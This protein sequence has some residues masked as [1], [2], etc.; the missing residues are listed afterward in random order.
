MNT[1]EFLTI[2]AAIVPDRTAIVG[3]GQRTTYAELQ[4]TANRLANALQTLGVA[5]GQN[6]GVMAVNSPAFV[7]VYY[8]TASVGAT[9]VPLNFRAKTEELTHMVN[10]ADVSVL[11]IGERYWPIYEQIK[12]SIP[13]VRQVIGL[14]FT[15]NGGANYQ[16]LIDAN[17]DI[18]VYTEIDDSD[19][20]LLIYTSGTTSLPKGVVLSYQA[21]TALVVNTQAPAD[22]GSEQEVVLVSAPFFHIAGATT[23]MSA[24]FSGRRLVVLPQFTPEAWLDAVDAEGVTHAFVVPTMLKRT[25]EYE[26]FGKYSLKT[27][28]LI[29]YGAAPMPYDVVRAAVE[30]FPPR[31]IGLLNAYGQTEATG[32]LTYLGPDDHHLNGTPEK[33]DKKLLRLRSVG[34]TMPDVDVAILA[35]DGRRL[36]GDDEGE[37]CIKGDRVMKGY[38]KRE[39]DTASAIHDGWLHTGD[40]GRIDED[41]YLFITGRIKDMIIRGGENISTAEIENVLE[42]HPGIAEAAVIGVPDN[43][44]GEVVKAI[45]VAG[46]KEEVPSEDDLTDYVKSRLASYKAPALYQW[47][48]ELPRNHLGKILKTELRDLYGQPTAGTS[49]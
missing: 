48:D 35:P 1:A 12:D 9:M 43:D 31:G 27:L 16:A 19:P 24:V 26:D 20:T 17:E 11:F 42:D 32:S 15:P 40:V 3:D 2:S 7:E 29:T 46:P 33:N 14:D 41:G 6:V 37:I 38:N 28:Q 13:G 47:V 5:K 36:S 39:A 18:P 49:V 4:S 25:M 21:L 10:E 45:I 22:P 8:A 23:I 44:W 34:K 30:I